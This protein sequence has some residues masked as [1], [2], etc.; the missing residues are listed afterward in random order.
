MKII[1]ENIIRSF[2][3]VKD[4]IMRLQKDIIDLTQAQE[5]IISRVE[6][7]HSKLNLMDN[8]IT[9]LE[10][11]LESFI[12]QLKKSVRNLSNKTAT[13]K[14]TTKSP[15]KFVAATNGTKFHIPECP[16]AKN[17]K[18]RNRKI[19]LSKDEALNQGLKPCHCVNS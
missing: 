16:F 1:E 10:K 5:R 12:P 3:F 18:P 14:K 4:D 2:R 17:I 19:F 9:K 11:K 7:L 6:D 15:V 8:R 13:A